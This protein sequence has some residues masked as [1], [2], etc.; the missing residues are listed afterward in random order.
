VGNKV[1]FCWHQALK[2]VF[3]V[4]RLKKGWLAFVAV[5]TFTQIVFSQSIAPKGDM[6]I[7]ITADGENRFEAG[8]AYASE[9]VVVHYGRD[10][11]Y[12]DEIAYDTKRKE[13]TAIGNVRIYTEGRFYR[14]DQVTFNFETKSIVAGPFW[15]GA[16]RFLGSGAQLESPRNNLYVIRDGTFTTEN[17]ENPSHRFEAGTIEIYSDDKIVLKNAVFYVSNIPVFW[18]PYYSYSLKNQTTTF[19]TSVGS[20]TRWGLYAMNGLR[21]QVNPKLTSQF[22]VDYYTR[23]GPGGGVDLDYKGVKGNK[24]EFRSFWIHDWGNEI[25]SESSDRLVVPQ[26]RRFRFEL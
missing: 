20:S 14:C 24:T 25:A 7:E 2:Y 10:V 12:A 15:Y 19:E 1:V 23:R 18:I 13:V 3:K 22:N 5:L 21:W 6:P 4:V 16:E 26:A 11:V 17:R 8:M 9:N